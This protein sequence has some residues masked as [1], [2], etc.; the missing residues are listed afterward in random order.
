MRER[1]PD[2]TDPEDT[3][4]LKRSRTRQGATAAFRYFCQIRWWNIKKRISAFEG[5]RHESVRIVR[6]KRTKLGQI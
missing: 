4:E 2:P 3:I 6:S 1:H 5:W